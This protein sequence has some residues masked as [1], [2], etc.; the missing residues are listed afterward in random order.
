MCFRADQ[1]L[2][3]C[4]HLFDEIWIPEVSKNCRGVPV[5]LVGVH[6]PEVEVTAA[7]GS[8]YEKYDRQRF[9]RELGAIKY[10]WC[11]PKTG[12]GVDDVFEAV[13]QV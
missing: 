10:I 1:P 12:E 8:N 5:V 9:A 2:G 13:S 11:N 4:R 6:D 7:T 3:L